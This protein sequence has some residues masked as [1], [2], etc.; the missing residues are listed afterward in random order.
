MLS[1]RSYEFIV[2]SQGAPLV[3]TSPEHRTFTVDTIDPKA[4]LSGP[5]TQTA[6]AAIGVTVS[7][8]AE[9]CK[10]VASGSV[11]VP[12]A[13]RIFRL[14]SVKRA[15]AA[16][17]RASL[18]LRVP[19]KAQRAIRAALRDDR[20]VAARITVKVADKAGNTRIRHRRVN[21]RR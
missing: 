3:E 9:A 17:H 7:C 12:G 15:V 14:R 4:R 8:G 21:L 18:K 19:A 16:N 1:D 6:D 10:V 5:L 20:K 2:Y 13:A 11:N